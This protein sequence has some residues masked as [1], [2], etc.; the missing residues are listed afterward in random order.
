MSTAHQEPTP[1]AP[2]RALRQNVS[3]YGGREYDGDIL[4]EPDDAGGIAASLGV[5]IETPAPSSGEVALWRA[6]LEQALKD[7]CR[8]RAKATSNRWAAITCHKRDR[9]RAAAR[10]WLKSAERD[11]SLVCDFADLPAKVVQDHAYELIG[12]PAEK[13]SRSLCQ[14]EW[15]A[16]ERAGSRSQATPV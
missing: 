12:T 2:G 14:V 4:D 3:P 11:F 10:A 6:V 8:P 1:S 9:A 15:R 7:A 5:I 13:R 16:P